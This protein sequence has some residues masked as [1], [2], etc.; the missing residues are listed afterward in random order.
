M[1]VFVAAGPPGRIPVGMLIGE[2]LPEARDACLARRGVGGDRA[3]HDRR[4]EERTGR[5]EVPTALFIGG[6]GPLL[7]K[8]QSA[9]TSRGLDA[10]RLLRALGGAGGIGQF[11]TVVIARVEGGN[12]PHAVAADVAGAHGFVAYTDLRPCQALAQRRS[13]S[14]YTAQRSRRPSLMLRKVSGDI[15]M[16]EPEAG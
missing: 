15:I 8:A 9:A 4:L 6:C 13:D 7:D 2:A 11:G 3:Q 16:P 14:P 12:V 10:Q 1:G 5:R